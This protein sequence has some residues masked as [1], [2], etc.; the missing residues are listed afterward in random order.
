MELKFVLF[1][2][3]APDTAPTSKARQSSL[4][5]LD[6]LL[7]AVVRPVNGHLETVDGRR[8]KADLEAIGEDG[9]WAIVKEMTDAE[10]AMTALASNLSRSAN[11]MNEARHL[12]ILIQQG[13]SQGDI[14][15]AL[16]VT[17]GLVSQRLQLLDLI[18]ELQD[19]LEHGKMPLSAARIAIKLPVELQEELAAMDKATVTAAKKLLHNYQ[20]EMV[21][22]STLEIPDVRPGLFISPETMDR[23]AAGETVGVKWC[24]QEIK[25]QLI[26][27]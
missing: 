26:T 13:W 11:P 12:A 22:L 21:D 18:P 14:A 27:V 1:D 10:A 25:L 5:K 9:M 7:P 24:D 2:K 20:T 3:I 15:K 4:L 16:G 8:R 17:Q 6:Q 19:R 23:L